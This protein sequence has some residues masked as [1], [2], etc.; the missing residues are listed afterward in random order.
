M[1]D[2]EANTPTPP[3]DQRPHE[4]APQSA[5]TPENEAAPVEAVPEVALVASSSPEQP[6]V[7]S[8]AAEAAEEPVSLAGET[9]EGKVS[10]E[11]SAEPAPAAEGGVAASE[12]SQSVDPLRPLVEKAARQR[13]SNAEEERA[14]T[15]IAE[16]LLGKKDEFIATVQLIPT[17]GWAI[18]SKAVTAAWPKMKASARTGLVKILGSVESEAG[19]RIRLS[20]GRSL[21][22]V[23]DLSASAKLITGVAREIRDKETGN[24]SAKDSQIFAN[25]MVGKGKPWIAQL[26]LADLKPVDAEAIVQTAIF[27]VFSLNHPPVTQIGVLKWA[28][29]NGRL[30]KLAEAPQA[31]VVKGLS[32]MS[33]KWQGILRKEVGELPESLASVLKDPEPRAVEPSA[34]NQASGAIAAPDPDEEDDGLP[35]EL[36]A[37]VSAAASRSEEASPIEESSTDEPSRPPRERPVYVSKTIPSKEQRSPANQGVQPSGTQPPPQPQGPPQGG[38]NVPQQ[39]RSAQFNLAE[40][41]RQ[42]E[43]HVGF[44]KNELKTAESKLRTREDDRRLVK[45]KPE[46][47][48][49]VGEPTIEELA[50]LNVQLEARIGELQTR[51]NDLTAD[52]E[53]RA[54][55]S[56]AFAGAGETAPPEQQ[57]RTLLSLKLQEAYADFCALE[58]EDPDIVVQQHYRTVLREVFEVLKNEKVPLD[59]VQ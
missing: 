9:L 34:N 27:V 4:A 47:P 31:W 49:I 55:S 6:P 32:R 7:E 43:A 16:R 25:V 59:E 26:A 10:N 23:P 17:V 22:K 28:A 53:A 58:K 21:F 19:R 36:R 8:I 2:T 52:A 29:E 37:E 39:A 41:L 12:E 38:R 30:D 35:A 46:V 45:K 40:A 18:A 51:I 57:L 5:P 20:I 13:L 11:D 54:A 48:V 50:R 33:G 42:I 1:E 56:G 3:D 15:L 14:A 44:L 24:V